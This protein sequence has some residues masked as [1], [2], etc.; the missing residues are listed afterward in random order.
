MKMP[1]AQLFSTPRAC[2]IYDA[3]SSEFLCISEE[4]YSFFEKA[5]RKPADCPNHD[6]NLES[7]S[8]EWVELQK[9]GYL[10]QDSVVK[11][12]RHHYTDFLDY[13]NKRK[14]DKITLQLTQ[15]CNLRC[16]YCVYSESD[17]TRQ[18]QHSKYKMNWDTAKR[19]ID[20]LWEHS[21]DSHD[22]NI[23][24]YGG[25]PLLEFEL[26][27]DIV[28]YCKMLFSGKSISFSLT[29]NGTLI[30]EK[31]ITYLQREKI[32]VMISLDGPKE[33]NDKNRV[34]EDG[35][36]TFDVVI[37][38]IQQIKE[39]APELA[40]IMQISMVIDP[41]ND[42]D[43]INSI[44]LEGA[45]LDKFSVMSSLVDYDYDD[46]SAPYSDD[47][48]E[49]DSYHQFLAILSRF[50][51]YSEEKLGAAVSNLMNSQIKDHELIGSA[52]GLRE[53]DVPSGPCIPGQVRL[54]VDIHGNLFPCERVSETSLSMS[55]GSLDNGFDMMN[56]KKML[57]VGRLTEKE[58]VD[59]WGFRHCSICI[60]VADDGS[61]HLSATKK[62]AA[63]E[64]VLNQIY[65]KMRCYLLF[66]E[67]PLFYQR[68]VRNTSQT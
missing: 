31:S 59:C 60:K 11:E 51:R 52:A 21:V 67:I 5:A 19:A 17:N 4:L 68:H 30:D 41:E 14:L 29:T 55:L 16:K 28:E 13:F 65:E 64:N 26:M 46:K 1:F 38:K 56:A 47:F 50:N 63:C 43:C 15:D 45:E 32:P 44:T 24:F 49:K 23:G 42:Y 33:V 34:F 48:T 66:K 25:E 6:L 9:L 54:F 3:N 40:E 20:F 62:L 57:N 35:T 37:S 36:G 18:R 2:Y 53:R 58:C 7:A 39:T 61:A 10:L 12:V 27:K 8:V 22:V